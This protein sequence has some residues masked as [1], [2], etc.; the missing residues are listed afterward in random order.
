MRPVIAKRQVTGS[1]AVRA[2]VLSLVLMVGVLWFLGD[3]GQ[4]HACNLGLLP[5]S[6][7]GFLQAKNSK[8]SKRVYPMQETLA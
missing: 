3:S 8:E 4:V 2:A 7:R 1:P 5:K 6:W